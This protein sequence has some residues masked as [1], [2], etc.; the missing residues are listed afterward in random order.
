[1]C[2]CGRVDELRYSPVRSVVPPRP[3]TVDL[4]QMFGPRRLRWGLATPLWVRANGFRPDR[5]VPALVQDSMLSMFGDWWVYCS[6]PLLSARNQLVKEV[7][8]LLPPDL[9]RDRS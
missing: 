1:M 8:L 7:G 2:D 9:V 3:V 5:D 6:V 4:S